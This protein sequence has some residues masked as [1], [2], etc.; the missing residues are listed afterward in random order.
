LKKIFFTLLAFFLCFSAF[1]QYNYYRLSLGAGAGG[2]LA[3]GDLKKNYIRPAGLITAEYNITPFAFAG[4][5]IQKGVLK[6]GDST[7][8]SIDPH[9]RAYKNNYMSVILSG[10]V[11][12][13]QFIDFES[14]NLLYAIRGFYIG[15]GVGF[16]KNDIA[17]VARIKRDGTNYKFF[18]SEKGGEIMIPINTGISF[19]FIDKWRFTKLS[20]NINYQLNKVFGESIDWYNDPS[21]KFRNDHSDFYGITSVGIKYHFGPEGL[22]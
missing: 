4:L 13:G 17:E 21:S 12:L 2:A 10:R 7:K 5:E 1:A 22:Y 18:G 15:T 8:A 11:Q 6:G 20:V 14:S 9:L 3:F 19:N 16:I